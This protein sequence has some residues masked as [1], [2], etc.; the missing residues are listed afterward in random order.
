[1]FKNN[2]VLT[3]S[4][5][6]SSLFVIIGVFFT[7]FLY[8]IANAAL[9]FALTHFGWFYLLTGITFVGFLVLLALSNYG[10]V[11]LGKDSEKPAYSTLSWVAMLFSAGMG[12][13]LVFWGVAEPVIFYDTPPY[14]SP[15]SDNAAVVGMQHALFHWGIHPWAIYGVIGLSLA[16]F[17]FRRGFPALISSAFYPILGDKIYG[18]PGKFIDVLAIFVTAI[19]VASTFGLSTLQIAAGLNAVYGIPNS[20]TTHIIIIIVATI[21]FTISASTGL[22]RGI[23]YLSNFNIFLM[24]FVIA[25]ILILGPTN[26]IFNTLFTSLG[27]YMNDVLGMSLRLGA[28]NDAEYEWITS[29]TVFYWA[30]WTTWAPFV[31]SFIARISRGRTIR[32][33]VAG[34]LLIPTVI[35]AI[36]F[37]VMGGSALH[38]IHKMGQN[39]LLENIINDIESSIFLFFNYFPLSEMISILVMILLL[40]F[41]ITSADSATVVLGMF[42]NNGEL[43]PN[44]SIKVLWGVI[45]SFASIVFLLA[46]GLDAVKTFSIVVASPF[47]IIMLF[48]IYSTVVFIRSESKE[49]V[50]R[51]GVVSKKSTRP[52]HFGTS[53]QVKMKYFE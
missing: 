15:H 29:W 40:V 16:Y 25:F 43:N 31:G 10:K 17:Q 30:W 34:V 4:V 35:S 49:K 53:E 3:Y 20:F 50:V 14:G 8:K 36:W 39:V 12:V 32:Q 13:G 41:F 44:L 21:I 19:G 6:V 27:R 2:P 26:H 28:F 11:K 52:I 18:G 46:G 42:S 1:M 5:I 33:F 24:F 7:D 48:M 45:V 47:T 22:N 51:R 23:K 37:S 38:L 9:N